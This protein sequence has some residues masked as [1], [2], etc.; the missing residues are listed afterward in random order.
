MSYPSSTGLDKV[1]VAQEYNPFRDQ[2]PR[3]VVNVYVTNNIRN[4]SNQDEC[5]CDLFELCAFAICF[6]LK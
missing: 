6:K 1:L 2:E 3:T 5:H 4:T